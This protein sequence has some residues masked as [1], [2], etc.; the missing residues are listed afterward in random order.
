MQRYVDVELRELKNKILSMG[1]FVERAIEEAIKALV[2]RN[3][4]P[5]QLVHEYEAQ[6]NRLHMEVDEYCL[7]L[8]ARQSPL[9]ADLRMALAI[10]KINSDLERMG[11]Q[12]VNIAHNC[13]HYLGMVPVKQLDDLPKMTVETKHMV[14]QA[15][16]AFMQESVVKGQEVLALDDSVDNF[17]DKIFSDLIQYMKKD[18]SVVEAAMHLILIARNLERIGD[19]ATNIAEDVIF[20]MTGKDVRHSGKG[21]LSPAR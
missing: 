6:I 7:K 17:K 2:E 20:A 15:L 9:A 5:L 18:P 11:D 8:L 13:K 12:A 21:A 3:P 1:G 19:H 16:D 10:I 14:R 4:A